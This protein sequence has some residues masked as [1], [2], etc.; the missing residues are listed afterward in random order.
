MVRED[1]HGVLGYRTLDNRVAVLVELDDS[2]AIDAVSV[3]AGRPVLL[4]ENSIATYGG[5][6]SNG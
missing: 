4:I 1:N 6:G 5:R 3:V 2:A